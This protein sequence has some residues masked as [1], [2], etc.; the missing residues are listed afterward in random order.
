MKSVRLLLTL[1]CIG[2]FSFLQAQPPH[3]FTYQAVVRSGGGTPMVNQTVALRFSVTDGAATTY[4]SETQSVTSNQFGLISVAVGNGTPVFQ[5]FDSIPWAS[6]DKYLATEMDINNG[7]NYVS[8]GA[9]Q[10]LSVPYAIYAGNAPTSGGGGGNANVNGTT[11]YL[12]KFTSS[13]SM[14]NSLVYDNGSYVGIGTANPG[15]LFEVKGVSAT[16]SVFSSSD[17]KGIGIVGLGNNIKSFYQ[18]VDGAGGLFAGTLTGVYGTATAISGAALYGMGEDS[19]NSYGVLAAANNESPVGLGRGAG[20][21]FTG[22][23]YGVIGCASGF[24]LS[25]RAGGIFISYVNASSTSTTYV[26]AWMNSSHYK[27]IGGGAVSTSVP[28]G[29]GNRV[30]LHAPETPEY[31]FQDYGEGKLINGKTHIDIDPIYARNVTINDKHPLRVFVQLQG[32]CN[33]VYVTNQ[34]ATGFDVVELKGGTSN[35]AFTWSITCNVAD[36]PMGDM[37]SRFADLRFEKLEIAK[38]QVIKRANSSTKK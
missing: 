24:N 13:S 31:Y 36:E 37:V 19:A 8:M 17:A 14:G 22:A 1:L 20:G 30:V 2:M 15:H 6:G 27:I 4:Y 34:S 12:G 18:P 16:P 35:T 21:S 32:D 23:Q 25:S 3:A 9:E 11:N 10:L 28:D 29:K 7:T 5:A 38:P 33:G 26:E